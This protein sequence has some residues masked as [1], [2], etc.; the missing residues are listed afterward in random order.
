MNNIDYFRIFLK[1]KGSKADL[2]LKCLKNS[3]ERKLVLH[4]LI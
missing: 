4:K 1:D 2:K 3:V